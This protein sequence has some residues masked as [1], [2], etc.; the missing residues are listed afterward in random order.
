M[1]VKLYQIV[2]PQSTATIVPVMALAASDARNRIGAAISSGLATRFI[3]VISIQTGI[4][5]SSEKPPRDMTVS[6]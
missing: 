6:T 4:S 1:S 2:Y 3:G 5:V